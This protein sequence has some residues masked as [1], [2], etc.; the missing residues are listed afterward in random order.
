MKIKNG[1][2]LATSITVLL[3]LP[4]VAMQFTNEVNWSS[5]DFVSAAAI[6]LGAGCLFLWISYRIKKR[7]MQLLLYFLLFAGLFFV[8]AELAVGIF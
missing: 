8:W 2:I 6:L 7:K 5:M 3:L 4:L 1:I